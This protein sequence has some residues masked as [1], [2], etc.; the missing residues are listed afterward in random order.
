MVRA[1]ISIFK[2][3]HF[4]LLVFGVFFALLWHFSIIY[5]SPFSW[6][7]NRLHVARLFIFYLALHAFLV[8]VVAIWA[9]SRFGGRWFGV[10][11]AAGY[12]IFLTI[13]AVDWNVLYYYGGHMDVLFWGQCVSIPTA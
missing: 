12:C 2:S 11:L 8:L 1:V 4:L 10:L 7:D 6:L 9:H 3:P 13:R 5:L